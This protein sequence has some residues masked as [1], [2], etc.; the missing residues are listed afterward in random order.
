MSSKLYYA[1]CYSECSVRLLY[2][3]Y[4]TIIHRMNVGRGW[5]EMYVR[6]GG[7]SSEIT[8]PYLKQA[9]NQKLDSTGKNLNSVLAIIEVILCFQP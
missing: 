4:G 9:K 2:N 7:R 3:N 5:G 1:I 8:E 6:V